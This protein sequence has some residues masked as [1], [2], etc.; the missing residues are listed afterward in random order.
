[1][2]TVKKMI[3]EL[4]KFPLDAKCYAY[5]GEVSGLG[6]VT[7]DNKYGFIFCSELSKDE[8]NTPSEE[9]KND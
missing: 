2:K 6:I 7:A 3:E 8:D 9:L 5:E 4:Q 1:M